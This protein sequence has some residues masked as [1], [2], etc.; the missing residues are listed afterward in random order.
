MT[1]FPKTTHFDSSHYSHALVAEGLSPFG[2]SLDEI[3]RLVPA[4]IH[5][6]ARAGVV[7]EI[8]PLIACL[9]HLG[10]ARPES[11]CGVALQDGLRRWSAP[12]DLDAA[13]RFAEAF[14]CQTLPGALGAR[15][16]AAI[17]TQ[18]FFDANYE[19]DPEV[20]LALGLIRLL[21]LTDPDH[22]YAPGKPN[23]RIVERLDP[24]SI[25]AWYSRQTTSPFHI[26]DG[27]RHQRPV[28][29][30]FVYRAPEAPVPEIGQAELEAAMRDILREASELRM[31]SIPNAA[32]V[33]IDA[34]PLVC[35][36]F[37]EITPD[38]VLMEGL[39]AE[40]RALPIVF[41]PSMGRAFG[42]TT[43]TGG[44]GSLASF[45]H[46]VALIALIGAAALRDFWV[47]EDR[48][49]ILG[50]ARVS[51]PRGLKSS[52][53]RV[54]YLPRIRYVGARLNPDGLKEQ[55]QSALARRA[56]W[57][58]SHFRRLPAGSTPSKKQ[59]LLAQAQQISP[60]P[61]TTWV[62][63]ARISGVGDDDGAGAAAEVTYRSRSA[64]AA[65][66]DTIP[67]EAQAHGGLSWFAF[68]RACARAL[69]A[70][71]FEELA[72]KGG[73]RGTDIYCARDRGH[74]VETWVVQCKHW[75]VKIGPETV[76][77]LHGAQALRAA[78][79]ALLITSSAFTAGA[80]EAAS[81]LGVDLMDSAALMA[82]LKI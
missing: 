55:A 26:D 75:S 54:I 49:K 50:P 81:A 56:H 76:R 57:R 17:R 40:G 62:R 74:E 64:T 6:I 46:Y 77:E 1:S 53:S 30:G 3:L 9:G 78:D 5:R 31:G 33:E 19:P 21:D 72:R 15:D 11:A 28:S 39:D 63:A 12:A 58:A 80:I 13:Y 4:A 7:A 14:I 61:G 59:L 45:E 23:A 34:S 82:G 66:F 70:Q 44:L 67:F 69:A 52:R 51:R 60:S 27:G 2:I 24:A 41:Q 47:I 79:R 10:D 71:G 29:R 25:F 8:L 48:D 65:L 22:A 42:P 32:F 18:L 43:G 20:A 68:E 35:L 16:I 37:A 73:D 36:C 38:L